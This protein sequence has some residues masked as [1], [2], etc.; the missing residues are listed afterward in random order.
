MK[1]TWV[2]GKKYCAKCNKMVTVKL[3]EGGVFV[4][5]DCSTII[6]KARNGEVVNACNHEGGK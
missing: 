3:I 2:G 1:L 4:C 6:K 5:I